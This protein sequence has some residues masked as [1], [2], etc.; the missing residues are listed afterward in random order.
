M[1]ITAQPSTTHPR[2]SSQAPSAHP[3]PAGTNVLDRLETARQEL[4]DLQA[5]DRYRRFHNDTNSQGPGQA[6]FA[7]VVGLSAGTLAMVSLGSRLPV[8]GA[9]VLPLAGMALGTVAGHAVVKSYQSDYSRR[10]QELTARIENLESAW[11]QRLTQL[12]GDGPFFADLECG[13]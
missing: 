1:K 13:P 3:I 2:L 9:L 6:A 11:A 10:E 5:L 12:L 8:Y 4:S 7:P